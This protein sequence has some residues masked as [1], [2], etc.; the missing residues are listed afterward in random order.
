MPPAE[1]GTAAA[2]PLLDHLLNLTTPSHPDYFN[3]LYDTEFVRG[4]P[5]ELRAGK[6][7]AISHGPWLEHPDLD[8]ATQ[9]NRPDLRVREEVPIV[10]TVPRGAPYSM[11][12]MNLAFDRQLVGP[13][14]YFGLMGAGQPWGRYDDLWAGWCSKVICDHLGYGVKTGRPYV[15]HEKASDWRANMRREAAGLRWAADLHAFFES[16]ALDDGPLSCDTVEECYVALAR[17]VETCASAPSTRTSRAS[18]APWRSGW[19]CRASSPGRRA[20]LETVWRYRQCHA[21][22][23]SDLPWDCAP[24]LTGLA[25]I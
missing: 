14:M 5:H 13:A 20:E 12:G 2:N 21:R 10:Q 16:V 8:A 6:P 17:Q 22:G 7:T 18:P 1:R 19:S 23:D 25:S 11:C 24:K 9:R 15:V 4:Y 3:T